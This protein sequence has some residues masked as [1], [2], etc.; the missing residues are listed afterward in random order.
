MVRS[1]KIGRSG[2]ILFDRHTGSGI[3]SLSS[4]EWDGMILSVLVLSHR[5]RYVWQ[6]AGSRVTLV[7]QLGIFF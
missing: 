7:R 4:A 1:A 3:S 6:V 5:Q 2:G